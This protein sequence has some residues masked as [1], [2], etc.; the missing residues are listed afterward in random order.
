MLMMVSPSFDGTTRAV[1][2][3]EFGAGSVAPVVG[4]DEELQ[5]AD[6]AGSAVGGDDVRAAAT[7][8][9]ALTAS[10]PRTAGSVAQVATWSGS[11]SR[12]SR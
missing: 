12:A 6:V 2:G 9:W 8:S 10:S 4:V 1:H 5:L 3:G 11:S 7:G